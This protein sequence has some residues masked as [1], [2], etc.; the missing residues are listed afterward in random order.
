MQDAVFLVP[1]EADHLGEIITHPTRGKPRETKA[2]SSFLRQWEKITSGN[3]IKELCSVQEGEALG[4]VVNHKAE[5]DPQGIPEVITTM[6]GG[7]IHSSRGR[8]RWRAKARILGLALGRE[9]SGFWVLLRDRT[10]GSS[11]REGNLAFARELAGQSICHTHLCAR[12]EEQTIWWE[13]ESKACWLCTLLG[14]NEH[15]M[16]ACL[17]CPMRWS[18]WSGLNWWK[19]KGIFFIYLGRSKSR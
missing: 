2:Q 6:C 4:S 3:I 7:Q 10:S 14:I 1:P 19:A 16:E 8:T 18:V 9:W 5:L 13:R 17:A 15:G 11:Y 12:V